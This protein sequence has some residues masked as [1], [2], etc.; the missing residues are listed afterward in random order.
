[1]AQR[2]ADENSRLGGETPLCEH[3]GHLHLRIPQF[4]PGKVP[5]PDCLDW[6]FPK[7]MESKLH[8]VSHLCF[9]YFFFPP[10][11]PTPHSSNSSCL[12]VNR[13]CSDKVCIG[14]IL[15]CFGNLPGFGDTSN[16]VCGRYDATRLLISNSM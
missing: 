3:L 7:V 13:G 1:M 16:L 2:G 15:L 14:L 10:E 6:L 11:D 9:K 5:R 4:T 8:N 12:W